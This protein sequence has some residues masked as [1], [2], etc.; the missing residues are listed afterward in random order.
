MYMWLV[1]VVEDTSRW[2]RDNY[3]DDNDDA[4]DNC[5]C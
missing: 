4:D 2:N 1:H 3:D 5:E